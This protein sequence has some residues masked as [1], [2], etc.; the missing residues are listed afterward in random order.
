MSRTSQHVFYQSR[1]DL[2]HR[3]LEQYCV[4]CEDI[5]SPEAFQVYYS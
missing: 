5:F 1:L 2:I 3:A 4:N